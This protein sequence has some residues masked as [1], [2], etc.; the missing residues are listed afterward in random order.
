MYVH[1]VTLRKFVR[2]SVEYLDI[3]GSHTAPIGRLL[4]PKIGV[5]A[6]SNYESYNKS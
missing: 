1:R 5:G 2:L 6:I 4:W 3:S